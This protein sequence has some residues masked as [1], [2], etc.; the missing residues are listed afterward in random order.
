MKK[1][2]F[3]VVIS[4]LILVLVSCDGSAN[5]MLYFDSNGGPEVTS[6][7]T[8]GNSAIL[9]PPNP[10][11]EGF[12]FAGWYWDDNSFENSFSAN[13]LLDSPI[14]ENTIVYAKWERD[15]DISDLVQQ[16]EWM[17]DV[18]CLLATLDS[19]AS[20]TDIYDFY[21]G[22]VN[23]E[24]SRTGA[25]T[26]FD[27]FYQTL[28]ATYYPDYLQVDL[29]D[30]IEFAISLMD[31]A[32]QG[33]ST[34]PDNLGTPM[35]ELTVYYCEL[36]LASETIFDLEAVLESYLD[37]AL[38]D[39]SSKEFSESGLQA[40]KDNSFAAFMDIYDEYIVPEGNLLGLT[41]VSEEYLNSVHDYIYSSSTV[42]LAY[43]TQFEGCWGL[44]KAL[45]EVEQAYYISQITES[46]ES[47]RIGIVESQQDSFDLAYQY[48]VDLLEEMYF[49]KNMSNIVDEYAIYLN[50]FS[51][52]E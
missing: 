45:K 22:L 10:T 16:M 46:Y 41:P 7:Q 8:D 6:I 9:I 43:V 32:I 13:S 15:F 33:W 44:F 27:Y 48:A 11:K 38:I 18:T 47:T 23:L 26:V 4:L 5:V 19:I 25:E 1:S 2:I 12:S 3:L 39:I 29:D 34:V 24:D 14:V 40:F 37:A 51:S 30:S 20:M 42:A 50:S 31:G 52:V 28:A 17:Y 35:V 36:I 21:L 49:E